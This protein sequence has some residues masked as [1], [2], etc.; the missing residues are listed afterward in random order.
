MK[1]VDRG[2]ADQYSVW[3]TVTSNRDLIRRVDERH[4]FVRDSQTRRISTIRYPW[5]RAAIRG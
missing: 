1:I 5:V 4:N 2:T 3:I